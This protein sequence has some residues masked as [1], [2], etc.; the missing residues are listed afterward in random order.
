M[1]RDKRFRGSEKNKATLKIK[2]MKNLISIIFIS[3]IFL[4]VSFA[5]GPWPQPKGKGY[6]KLSE[7]WTVFDQHYTDQGLIDPNV[8][9]GI[10]NTSLY[11]EFGITNRLT[12]QFNGA[13]LSRNYMNNLRSATTEELLVELA[14]RQQ[15]SDM[16]KE[17]I[18]Q[19]YLEVKE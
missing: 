1:N 15:L 5:G 12:A 11:A 14:F 18:R 17:L 13:L 3:V 6:F 19:I 7:W 16:Q 4:N 2:I 8:T 10:F 9:T